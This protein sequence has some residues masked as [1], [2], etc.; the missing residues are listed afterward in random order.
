MKMFD[1]HAHYDD[2]RFDGERDILLNEV[3]SL[4]VDKIT[5]IGASLSSSKASL[6]LAEKFDIMSCVE[7]GSCSYNCP[8]N[9]P[10]VQYIRAAK[11]QIR[12]L[13]KAKEA[14]LAA[15]QKN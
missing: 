14:S 7:C 5:N 9:V 11:G 15:S 4:G 1:S 13:Q 12:D 6:E 3:H 10:I 2:S 8:G